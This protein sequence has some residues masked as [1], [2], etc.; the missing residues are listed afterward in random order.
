MSYLTMKTVLYVDDEKSNLSAFQSLYRRKFKVLT[1]SSAEEG[2]KVLQDEPVELIVTDQRMPK[3]TGVQ[4]LKEVKETHPDL[5]YILLTAY[6]DNEALKQAVNEVGIYW[7]INK[8]FD[9]HQMEHAINR[10]IE[11][12]DAER[13]L[14]DY[15]NRLKKLVKELTLAE[16]VQR[17]QIAS[18]LHDEVGQILASA[19]LQL[20]ALNEELENREHIDKLEEISEDCLRGIKAVRSAIF[21]LSY[22]QLHETGL[23]ASTADWAESQ[24]EVKHDIQVQVSGEESRFPLNENTRLLLFRSIRELLINV[25]KHAQASEVRIHFEQVEDQLKIKVEDDGVGFDYQPEQTDFQEGGYGIFSILQRIEDIG[26]SIDIHSKHG[27]GTSVH[28]LAPLGA[29]SQE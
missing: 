17:K 14:R 13:R 20:T 19:R 3:M 7:Y 24:L 4:F 26:G 22:P 29:V 5:K 11:A 6:T 10:G 25:R 1:A 16:E 2:L 8:P 18:D 12:R 23:Y 21:D 27:Q 15:Q 28:L 9:K